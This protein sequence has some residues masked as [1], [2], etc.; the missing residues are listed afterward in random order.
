MIKEVTFFL[1]KKETSINIVIKNSAFTKKSLSKILNIIADIEKQNNL[2]QVYFS[3]NFETGIKLEEFLSNKQ[4]LKEISL[5]ISLFH[6]LTSLIEKSKKIY[7]V[8]L[9]NNITGP[10]MEIAIACDYRIAKSKCIF[11]FNETSIGLMPICG[12]LQR[13]VRLL[14]LEKTINSILE[15]KLIT[16]EIAN[17]YKL[18]YR[19]DLSTF[20]K[21]Q[22]DIFSKKRFKWSENMMNTFIIKNAHIHSLKKG[23]EP[24]FTAIMSCI[25]E[26][27]MCGYKASLDIEKRWCIWLLR[28][29]ITYKIISLLFTHDKMVLS[30]SKIFSYEIEIHSELYERLSIAYAK[31]GVKLL[32]DGCTPSLIENCSLFIGFQNSP[33]VIADEIGTDKLGVNAMKMYNINRKGKSNLKG[34]YEYKK[35]RPWHLC[36]I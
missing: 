10:A 24:S 36:I 4:R 15:D 13:L 11:Y 32:A 30:N 26:G 5:F 16:Y 2:K 31:A 27:L 18:L 20:N 35:D 25:Y 17:K 8:L 7:K 6:E 12:T 14:G 34:F 22:F 19:K 1:E 33:L 29:N 28:Q 21:K 9:S 23:I 3:G